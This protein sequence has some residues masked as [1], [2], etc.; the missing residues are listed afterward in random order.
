M[1]EWALGLGD[2]VELTISADFRLCT[3]DYTDDHIWELVVG[4]EPPALALCTTYGLRARSMRIFPRF[5]LASQT[6][7][8][9]AAFFAAPRLRRFHPNFLQLDFFPFQDIDVSAEYWVPDSHACAGRLSLTNRSGSPVSLGLE[10]CVQLIPLRRGRPVAPLMAESVNVLTGQT[11]GLAPVI[12]LTGGPQP[13]T[14][15][16]PSLLISRPLEPGE[17]RTLTW[18][19]AALADPR[20]SL[21][22]ARR[23]AAQPWEPARA[24]IE[25]LNTAQSVEVFTGNL[26]WDAALALAQKTAFR[27]FFGA[28][29]GLPWPSFVLARQPDHGHSPGGD[30]TDYPPAWSGQ[31]PFETVYLASLLPGAPEWAA[32]LLRNFLSARAPDGSIP[33]KAGLAGQR[34]PWLAAPLLSGLAW[35]VYQRTR[36]LDFLRE[37]QPGLVAFVESWFAPRHD[38]DGDGFPEWDQPLQ[39]GFEDNPAFSV[40]QS[41]GQGADITAVESPALAAMLSRELGSLAE[42]A[43]AL[44]QSREMERLQ[45]RREELRLL[46]ESCWDSGTAGY[47][48]RDRDSHLSPAGKTIA[49]LTG[50]GSLALEQAFKEPR[51]L[52]V[53]LGLQGHAARRP[54][55]T[56]SGRSG[57]VLQVETLERPDFQWGSSLAVATSHCLF[58]SL[59]QVKVAGIDKRDRMSLLVADF[60]GQ[61][62]T[63]FLPLWGADAGPER[64][65]LLASQVLFAPSRFGRPFGIPACPAS[66]FYPGRKVPPRV[67]AEMDPVCESVHLPWNVLV[68]QGLLAGGLRTEAAQMCARLMSAVIRNLKKGHSF[69]SAYHAVTGAGIGERNPLPGLAPLGL[70][71][72]VLGLRI[73]SPRRIVLSGKN[74]YPWPVTVKYRGLM[75]NRQ[76]EQTVVVF[77][78]GQTHTLADPTD[79]VV[80]LD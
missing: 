79:A 42:I 35:E 30:G 73:E 22:F 64:T 41:G 24:R 63:L 43:G 49:K 61:D 53:R 46:V 17:T 8:D 56:L 3:P 77:P 55:V 48:D 29:A 59:E 47:F 32:G 11:A 76:A 68:I 37:V 18:A 28:S 57:E 10:L 39:T 58:T 36:D 40:W 6:V 51:R 66:I 44:G 34:G 16:Y 26:E 45:A 80:S 7:S 65:A 9:P 54:A 2:P 78:D 21:E 50:P 25:L 60:S 33:W 72:D 38:R 62:I 14:G 5:S 75:V 74:P 4:G 20:E 52:L 19:Q 31:S 13:G 67:S 12:F 23:T 69:S 27:L 70:F 71:L 1:R 15:P